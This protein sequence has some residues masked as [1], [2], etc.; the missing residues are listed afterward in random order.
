MACIFAA[1]ATIAATVLIFFKKV[2]S[3]EGEARRPRP[4]PV[5]QRDDAPAGAGRR[6]GNIRDRMQQARREE[7]ESDENMEEWM[8]EEDDEEEDG[9]HRDSTGKKIGAKKAKKLEMKAERQREREM[10]LQEREEEKERREAREEQRR[11][12]TEKEKE[13]EEKQEEE[14]RLKKEEQEKRD[15]EEYLKM[16]EAFVIEEEGQTQVLSD[17]E[18]QSLLTE[19]INYIKDMKVVLLEDLGAQF[20]IRTQEAINRVHELQAEGR[21]TGVIDDRGKFI[22]I[23][24]EELEAVAKFIRQRGRV[25]I[26]ELAEASNQLVSLNPENIEVYQSKLLSQAV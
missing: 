16:K 6:R 8:G 19:F 4:A 18:S 14:E 15:H 10:M 20:N 24:E 22:Y 7:E 13:E 17:N 5:R 25:S 11:K 3:D 2:K 23:S 9:E 12:I 1:V 21:L 26:A